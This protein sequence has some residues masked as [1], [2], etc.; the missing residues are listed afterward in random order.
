MKQLAEN[1]WI[2]DGEAVPFLKLPFTTRMTVV[3][4]TTGE[5]W[6]HSPIRF[7]DSI[8]QQID[9]LGPVKYLVAPNHLHH[10]FLA[11][12]LA[13]YSDAISYA[14]PELIKKRR[15]LAFDYALNETRDW[16]WSNELAHVLFTG[17]PLMEE[18]VFFHH[19]SRVLIVTDLIEN[20]SGENFSY[21]QRLFARMAGVLAPHGK[22]PL[23]WR[24]SFMFGKAKARRHLSDIKGWQPEM[25]VMSHGEIIESGAAEFLEKSFDW[26]K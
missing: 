21:W 13:H 23:D 25:I 24:L 12:W 16:P 22:T 11:E 6:V 26:I 4:L 8:C 5:L 17:S 18:S 20:F 7:S 1:L 14:T 9:Q 19:A 2:F 10:L 15:D 3:R